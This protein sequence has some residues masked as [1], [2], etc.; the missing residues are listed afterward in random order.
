M[1]GTDGRTDGRTEGGS[2]VSKFA[3]D[4]KLFRTINASADKQQLQDAIDELIK[5]MFSNFE[6][7]KCLHTRVNY[8]MGGTILCTSR[9]IKK[10]DLAVTTKCHNESSRTM[11]NC[12]FSG[13]PDSWNDSETY[14][15]IK[16]MN[17]LY[18]VLVPL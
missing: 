15:I 7:Y 1:A 6:K 10:N 4:T 16:K 8:E 12:S 13:K 5:W 14:N 18:N 2:K 11:Q 9:T 17:W 3:D